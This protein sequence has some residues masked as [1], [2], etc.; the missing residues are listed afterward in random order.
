MKHSSP[1]NQAIEMANTKFPTKKAATKT[2]GF[3]MAKD[4]T[5]PRNQGKSNQAPNSMKDANS[6]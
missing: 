4:H 2:Q 6:P 3:S 1:S 5:P